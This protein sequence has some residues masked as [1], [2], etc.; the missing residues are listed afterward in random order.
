M[1]IHLRLLAAVIL[2]CGLT[3]SLPGQVKV[4][5]GMLILPAYDEG[6]PDPNPPFDRFSTN[7]FSYPY[8]LRNN[9][10]EHRVDHSW[11]AIYLE[12]EYLKCSILPDIGGHLYT[13]VDKIAGKPMFYANP[14]I[15]KADIG[16]R[17]AWAAF[18]IEF[19]FPVSHN[20]V[21]MSPVDFSFAKHA[22]GSA[23]V[24]VGNVDRVYGME[25]SV[26]L[27]LRPNS[28]VLEEKVTLN[29]RSDARHRFYWW[30]NAAIEVWDDSHIEYPMQFAASHG[31]TEIQPWPVDADGTDLSIIR[32]Q[33]KGPVSL[34]VHGSREPFM[35]IWNPHTNTGTVHF[36]DYAQL[37]GKK[38][39]SWG[40]DADALDWRHALSDDNSAYVEVQA[41]PFRNQET[42]AFLEPRQTV[43]FSEFWMPVRNIGGISRAN[44]TG[45]VEL[46]RTSNTLVVGFNANQPIPHASLR[47]LDGSRALLDE[48][49]DLVPERTWKHEILLPDPQRK[50][51]F[52]V[53]DAKGVNL[54]RQTEDQYDWAPADQIQA[55]PQPHEHVAAAESRSEDEWIQL[56]KEQELNGKLLVALDT[57]QAALTKFPESFAA[58]KA[59]GRLTAS[60]LRFPDA[61][62]Y[63]EAVHGR[64]TTDAE[65]TYYLGLAYDGLGDPTQ[66]RTDFESAYR[67]PQFRAAA[68]LRL[69]ELS[70]REG[71]LRGAER[72]L[73]ES[74]EAAYGDLRAAEELVAIRGVLGEKAEARRAAE[75]WAARYPLSYFLREE[76]GSADLAHLADDSERIL[77]IASEFMR[78]GLYQRAL[79]VLSR[80]YPPPI[81]DQ[82]EP[83]VL[84][85]GKNPLIGYFRGFCKMKLGQSASADYEAASRLSTEYIFP[86][87]E[88]ELHVLQSALQTNPNDATARYL[89]G[90][91]Y[92][93]LGRTDSALAE[94]EEARKSNPKIPVLDASIG[95]AILHEKHAPERA[96]EAF[97]RGL[98][99]DPSNAV[100]Y[101]GIDQALSLLG[102]SSG[103]RI[104]ALERYPDQA[105]MPTDVIY[106]LVLNLTEAGEYERAIALFHHR[107]FARQEGGTNVRQVWIEVQLQRMIA[108]AQ[109]GKCGDALAVAQNLGASVPDL[110]FTHDGL[111]PILD[112]ARTNFLLG[113]MYRTCGMA[114]EAESRF[115][116]TASASAP[117][118][119]AWAW[120]AAQKLPGFDPQQWNQRLEATRAQAENLVETSALTSFWVYTLGSLEA[121][122]GQ[123][124]QAD[125]TFRKVFLLPDRMLAYHLTRLAIAP[126]QQ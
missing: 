90:T 40:V 47:I 44:L 57:Y 53:L 89:L 52:E 30:N 11:R 76:L 17:G 55:G 23:S 42:Y 95:L 113:G 93:S 105:K 125:A 112:N 72:Y 24:F 81:A 10:T 5:Q 34:F 86:S 56:G 43:R 99:S 20:W 111:K 28:T 74:L 96:L 8:T 117:G 123:R 60:L 22:D 98:Q 70:A 14:S 51:A 7:R 1:R 49:A 19:N 71:D 13:C 120:L 58:L 110:P 29:N 115:Q 84:P 35:G 21:S 94:W 41:G 92:C 82:S 62:G 26:E 3:S 104:Q 45:V 85:P 46:R 36:A 31:F 73:A 122:L 59:A 88:A 9:L 119:M 91:L 4:W 27:V 103:E 80:E 87:G 118:Q 65:I 83:G 78:L 61:I 12:N 6:Q 108:L 126:K 32:D 106:E 18:G 107:F 39:W 2:V 38:I 25:W 79:D 68:G 114:K 75:D 37:P 121:A 69:G 124:Q 67:L 102:Q 48:K 63:L 16:Y 101:L 54:L 116:V 50:Y 97:E 64:D 77:N 15:K 100:V 109:A 33:T 66:A